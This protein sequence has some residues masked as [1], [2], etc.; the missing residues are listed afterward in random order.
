[1]SSWLNHLALPNPPR[2]LPPAETIVSNRYD[3]KVKRLERELQETKNQLERRTREV[4]DWDAMYTR[5]Q[6]AFNN[7]HTEATQCNQMYQKLR[8][9]FIDLRAMADRQQQQIRN[10][11]AI[12]QT[13]QEQIRAVLNENQALTHNI[14][15]AEPYTPSQ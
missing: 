6:T 3:P 15:N 2:D 10:M 11:A 4:R 1:M 9:D 12:D 14:P 8:S 7:L 5:L 13:R